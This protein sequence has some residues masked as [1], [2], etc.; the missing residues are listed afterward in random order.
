MLGDNRTNSND[1]RFWGFTYI[2]KSDIKGEVLIKYYS[3]IELIG[4]NDGR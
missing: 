1:S 2:N 4:G 3:T